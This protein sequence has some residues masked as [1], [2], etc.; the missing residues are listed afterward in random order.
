M[1]KESGTDKARPAHQFLWLGNLPCLDLVNTE[2]MSDG[3][4]VDRLASIADLLAWLGEAGILTESAARQAEERLKGKAEA[5]AVFRRALALRSRLR[6]MA[7]RLTEGKGP[8]E[9]QLAAINRVLAEQ[10]THPKL[11]RRPGGW[12]LT[13]VPERESAMQLLAP[14]AESA[15]WLIAEGNLSLL[16][17]CENPRCVLY[18]YDTTRNGRRRWCSMAGCGSRAKAAA[19]YR[20]QRGGRRL[21]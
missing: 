14:L 21:H 18:F 12:V 6:R 1:A 8:S 5:S 4:P 2:A 15:A 11:V 17:R 20:R 16:R 19:Y 9:E 3:V 7:E 13:K 10:P